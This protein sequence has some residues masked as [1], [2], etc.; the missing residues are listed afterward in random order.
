MPRNARTACPANSVWQPVSESTFQEHIAKLWKATS[1]KPKD[2]A[3][4][5]LPAPGTFV[6]DNFPLAIEVQLAKGFAFIAEVRR[7]VECVSAAA[8]EWPRNPVDGSTINLAS[9]SQ[10]RPEVEQKLKQIALIMQDSATD[11]RIFTSLL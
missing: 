8:I 3:V 1:G 9:N 2:P 10:I 7:G 5:E 4:Y 11:S 6:E